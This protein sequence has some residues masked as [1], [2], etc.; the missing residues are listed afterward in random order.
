MRPFLFWIAFTIAG[1]WVHALL[2][3]VDVFA[4][5]LVLCLHIKA[6]RLAM[7]LVL[8]WTTL[9]EGVGA[10]AFGSTALWYACIALFHWALKRYMEA[11]N[12]LFVALVALF[13]GGLK[14]LLTV[15]TAMLEGYPWH[16]SIVLR[17][18]VLQAVTFPFSWAV[19]FFAYRRWVRRE[20]T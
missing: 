12:I 6:Y 17:N 10:A 4:A 20:E 8:I 13:V 5:G 16:M 2:P 15:V 1:T 9:H 7:A 19:T 14:A 11:E 3:T 18:G